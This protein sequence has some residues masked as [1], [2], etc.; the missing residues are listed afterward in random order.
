MLTSG[1]KWMAIDTHV[2]NGVA[3]VEGGKGQTEITQNRGRRA[4]EK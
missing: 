1:H 2:K 4:D 3:L